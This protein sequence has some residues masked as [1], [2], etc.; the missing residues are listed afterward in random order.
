MRL[1]YL[2]I[3]T[4]ERNLSLETSRRFINQ[5][6]YG[7]YK[8]LEKEEPRDE[9][10]RSSGFD[11]DASCSRIHEYCICC[12]VDGDGIWEP[13]RS[14]LLRGLLVGAGVLGFVFRVG[15][16]LVGLWEW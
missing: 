9:S 11:P 1:E 2:Q 5:A 10:I 15:I 13:L 3:N 7:K 16:A 14:P 12:F 8:E 4:R 6:R